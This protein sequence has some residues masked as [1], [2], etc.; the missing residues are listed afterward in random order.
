MKLH[1]SLLLRDGQVSN[2]YFIAR[3]EVSLILD[4]FLQ[5]RKHIFSCELKSMT[6]EGH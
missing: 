2:T 5:S 6:H 3:I 1:G 4:I